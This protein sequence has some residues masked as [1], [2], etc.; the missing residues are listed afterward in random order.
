MVNLKNKSQISR[1]EM[2][3]FLNE[4]IKQQ[5]TKIEKDAKEEKDRVEKEKAE[6]RVKKIGQIGG[7][8]GEYFGN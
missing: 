3:R 8:I 7:G 4:D 1:R 5:V 6:Q 2:M